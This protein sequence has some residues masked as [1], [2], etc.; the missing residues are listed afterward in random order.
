MLDELSAGG[1]LLPPWEG[2]GKVEI[3]QVLPPTSSPFNPLNTRLTFA[4]PGVLILG[5]SM[6]DLEQTL[7]FDA[8]QNVAVLFIRW[9]IF[10]VPTNNTPATPLC[11]LS[12]ADIPSLRIN[13][14]AFSSGEPP[15]SYPG[16][17][18]W[19][20]TTLLEGETSCINRTAHKPREAEIL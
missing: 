15:N 12:T 1:G 2:W 10:P 11:L 3:N 14:A 5:D 16:T 9:G 18:N 13:L 19:I 8:G 6:V 20:S 4:A 7:H 17:Q